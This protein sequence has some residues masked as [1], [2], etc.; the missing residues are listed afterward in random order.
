MVGVHHFVSLQFFDS[1]FTTQDL[2][3]LTLFN[4]H[5]VWSGRFARCCTYLKRNGI[6]KTKFSAVKLGLF[7]NPSLT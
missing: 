7:D 1:V 4:L 5:E 2:N 6:E 3:E